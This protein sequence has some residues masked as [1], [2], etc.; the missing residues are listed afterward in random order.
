MTKRKAYSYVRMS[1]DSQLKGD[2]LRRQLEASAAYAQANNLEL[3]D[4]IDG[5]SLNDIGV[6]AFNGINTQKGALATFLKAL[7]NNLIEPN[8]VLLVESLDRLSRDRIS[9]AL[10]QFMSILNKGIEIVTLADNQKYTK[11]IINTN[12]G[13]IFI[14]LGSML[15]ANEESEIKAKRL[16]AA[17][18]NKRANTD[19]SVLTRT[20]P[21]W[22]KYSESTQ[23]FEVVAGRGEVV[24]KI[25][26]MSVQ[27][28]GYYS[29]TRH[30]N[31]TNVPVFGKSKHWHS[32]YVKKI[33]VNRAAFG[34]FQPHNYVE[35]VRTKVGDPIK[36]YFPSVITEE[37]FLLAQDSVLRRTIK[38][39]GRKGK[40]FT[41]LFSG[42]IYCGHCGSSMMVRNRGSQR[43]SL[44]YMLCNNQLVKGGCKMTPW[45]LADLDSVLFKHLR[46]IDFSTLLNHSENSDQLNL[47]DRVT[48]LNVKLE[49]KNAEIK[50]TIDLTVAEG[51]SDSV[52]QG[53][54][55]KLEESQKELESLDSEILNLEKQIREK[56]ESREMLNNTGLKVL[57]DQIEIHKNDYLFRSKLNQYLMKL[58]DEIKLLDCQDQFFPWEL[59]D[60]DK[61]VE[62]FRASYKIRS[63]LTLDAV[64][65]HPEFEFFYKVFNRTIDIKYKSGAR[66]HLMFG[67]DTS[68]TV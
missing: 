49:A 55:A 37:T 44:K 58:I 9:E 19:K 46:E 16:K 8:S 41:N 7:E 62:S 31:E 53:F 51:V 52:R 20:C 56:N 54:L 47:E 2:S 30:L 29:I 63:N 5:I 64:L 23:V 38:S 15:R 48:A 13:S 3:I 10:P 26:E 59:E 60:S 24:K 35:G 32:S 6:S 66:R 21:A 67:I 11:D 43:K 27:A 34:E 50:R 17:W 25:F 18:S 12:P 65:N 14:S 28:C 36:D 42:L 68:L 61:V 1:T 57:I 40:S 22:L 33:L 45:N 39:A 4:S